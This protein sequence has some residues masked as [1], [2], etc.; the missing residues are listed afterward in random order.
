MSARVL[1]IAVLLRV[2]AI[3]AWLYSRSSGYA[4]SG[5]L[6]TVL[7]AMLPARFLDRV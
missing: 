2:A 3:R 7:A 5:L 4:P 1:A 6:G